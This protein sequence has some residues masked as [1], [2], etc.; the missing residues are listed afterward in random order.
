MKKWIRTFVAATFF[1]SSLF[2]GVK[3]VQASTDTTLLS[4]NDKKGD[5]LVLK[6]AKEMF[7]QKKDGLM[8]LAW[9]E[10][11]SSHY[12]HSSHDSHYSHY[13]GY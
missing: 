2:M 12:S 10:S 1:V 7:S 13:S 9:H 3:G 6:H 5:L 8:K 4:N 11:H